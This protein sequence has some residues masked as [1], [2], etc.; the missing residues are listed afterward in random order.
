MCGFAPRPYKL[1][2]KLDQN[3]YILRALNSIYNMRA[4][5]LPKKHPVGLGYLTGFPIHWGE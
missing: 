1:L 2:K 5:Q 3:F 4:A